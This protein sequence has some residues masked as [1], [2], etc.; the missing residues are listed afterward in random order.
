MNSLPQVSVHDVAEKLRQRRQ[1]GLPFILLDVR[2]PDEYA[3]ANLDGEVEYAPLSSLAQQGAA[4]LPAAVQADQETEI[5]VMCHH[6]VR[7][8]QVTMWLRRQGWQN[9]FN[10]SGGINAYAQNVDP[11][12]GQY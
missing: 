6:G 11:T 9:V 4:A 8:A 10:M 2:E 1:D 12:I 5:V 3:Y 7:S